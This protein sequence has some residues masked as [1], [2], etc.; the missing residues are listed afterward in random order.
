VLTLAPRR[1]GIL[2]FRA[3]FGGGAG[4]RVRQLSTGP[5]PFLLPRALCR[6]RPTRRQ[7]YAGR[8]DTPLPRA[9][10]PPQSLTEKPASVDLWFA[11]RSPRSTPMAA[12]LPAVADGAA[13]AL[14]PKASA[15]PRTAAAPQVPAQIV[16]AKAQ[17]VYVK[18]P[19]LGTVRPR[20]R[21]A[22]RP[23]RSRADS[24]CAALHTAL[25]VP[26]AL[27]RLC[28]GVRSPVRREPGAR[29]R[30]G[31][32]QGS[33]APPQSQRQGAS[34]GWRAVPPPAARGVAD[35]PPACR[36]CS[37]HSLAQL[38]T[39]IRIHRSLKHTN[40]VDFRH[41]FEDANNVYIILE[42][43]QNQVRQPSHARAGRECHRRSPA[44]P[45]FSSGPL[46]SVLNRRSP[47][48]S[49]GASA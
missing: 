21:H 41:Y 37:F 17:A 29:G 46:G 42:L 10:P 3:T 2:Y 16:D 32:E 34:A 5:P 35:V 44:S 1:A 20:D 12:V 14:P 8:A 22:T 48:W 49:S 25:C 19:L 43:C 38:A 6:R 9:P 18:G 24:A 4:R 26:R 30:Q 39:E 40:I 28:V 23:Q 33:P 36:R 13:P 47:S 11:C 31:R 45:R 27:G 15:V 7:Q